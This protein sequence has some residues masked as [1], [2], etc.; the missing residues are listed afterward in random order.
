MDRRQASAGAAEP[1]GPPLVPKDVAAEAAVWITRLHGGQRTPQ[2][3]RECRAWQAR[4]AAHRL[5]FERCTDT[6]QDVARLTLAGYATATAARELP[7]IGRA[8]RSLPWRSSLAIALAL[9]ASVLALRPWSAEDV[10]DTGVGEQR[11]VVLQDGTRLSLNTSTRI[12]VDFAESQ[13]TVKVERGEALF[14]VAKD[15]SRPFVVQAA[16]TEVVATGTAFLVKASPAAKPGDQALAVTLVEGQVVVRSAAS[17]GRRLEKPLVMVPGQRLRLSRSDEAQRPATA[18]R[19]DRPLMDQV[20]AWKRGEARFD[21]VSL[22][23]AVEEMNR[24]DRV[25]IVVSGTVGDRRVSG[26]VKT[27]DNVSFAEAMASLHGL[28]VRNHG[29][30]LELVQP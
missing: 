4:S 21:N 30:R 7:D 17:E 16:G 8:A 15:A 22:R 29:D 24:Y 14:E 10:Y 11:V 27:G 23:E 6:W 5:A 26:V 1:E 2:M 19:V 3:E 9:V 28:V 25:S 18:T 13:R 12:R 20:L